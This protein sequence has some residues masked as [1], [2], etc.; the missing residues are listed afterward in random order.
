MRNFAFSIPKNITATEARG[1]NIY[2]LSKLTE[3]ELAY[4]FDALTEAR[5]RYVAELARNEEEG[6][7]RKRNEE[8]SFLGSALAFTSKMAFMIE[9]TLYCQ[10]DKEGNS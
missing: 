7:L 1:E 2:E 3:T 8:A 6:E 10:N 9:D 5:K 4:V